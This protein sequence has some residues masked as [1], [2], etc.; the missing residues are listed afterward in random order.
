[1]KFFFPEKEKD[2]R[3]AEC[4]RLIVFKEPNRLAFFWNNSPSIPRIRMQYSV[5]E[6]KLK[7]LQENLT[8]V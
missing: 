6:V 5:I 4:V 2:L 8:R 1:M 7:K 3:E